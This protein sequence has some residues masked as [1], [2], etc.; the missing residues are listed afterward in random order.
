MEYGGGGGGG[1][2]LVRGVSVNAG[3]ID[4]SGGQHDQGRPVTQGESGSFLL[5][6]R[7]GTLSLSG[8]GRAANAYTSYT[9]LY[10]SADSNLEVGGAGAVEA[11]VISNS[12]PVLVRGTLSLELD[13][14]NGTSDSL[15][16]AQELDIS[17]ATLNLSPFSALDHRVLILA[18]YGS[19]TGRFMATNGLPEDLTVAYDHG[20]ASNQIALV[21]HDA[22]G[23]GMLDAWERDRFASTTFSDGTGHS[24]ADRYTDLEEYIA[25][26]DPLDAND[27]LWLEITATSSNLLKLKLPTSPL[28]DYVIEQ[29]VGLDAPEFTPAIP[30]FSGDG[31]LMQKEVPRDSQRLYYRVGVMVP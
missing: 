8:H 11:L 2:I 6:G 15:Q 5:D 22:D 27:F 17:G 20:A 29:S 10:V 14:E 4:V 18:S 7:N 26:T 21:Q 23:D 3:P 16:V 25:D 28:R 13:G 1:R 30:L 19:L 9:S 24:D 12:A 31:S